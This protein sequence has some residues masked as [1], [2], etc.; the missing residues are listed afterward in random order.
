MITSAP[1]LSRVIWNSEHFEM[2]PCYYKILKH[3]YTIVLYF[4]LCLEINLKW[5]PNQLLSFWRG[6]SFIKKQSCMLLWRKPQ[7]D[8]SSMMP[9]LKVAFVLGKEGILRFRNFVNIH[10]LNRPLLFGCIEANAPTNKR[11]LVLTKKEKGNCKGGMNHTILSFL[12]VLLKT[13]SC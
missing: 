8:K 13:L 2:Q 7:R 10:H 5:R 1:M 6:S 12:V 11:Q 3:R 4:I 9:P